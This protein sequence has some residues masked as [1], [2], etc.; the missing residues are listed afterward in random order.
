M[1]DKT[2]VRGLFRVIAFLLGS[3]PVFYGLWF[4][5]WLLIVGVFCGAITAAITSA[6]AN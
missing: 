3:G 1:E 6:L 5:E 2:F 4:H